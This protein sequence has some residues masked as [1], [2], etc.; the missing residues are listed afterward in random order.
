MMQED[1]EALATSG[2]L[3]DYLLATSIE[4]IPEETEEVSPEGTIRVVLCDKE[5]NTELEYRLQG[6]KKRSEDP[7]RT[8]AIRR[9][10]TFSPA[11]RMDADYVCK[12]STDNL[13]GLIIIRVKRHG[14][15]KSLSLSGYDSDFKFVI[16]K[17]IVAVTCMIVS[18]ATA[19]RWMVQYPTGDQSMLRRQWLGAVRQLWQ[20]AIYLNHIDLSPSC[21]MM[22]LG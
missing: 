1:S 5:T 4:D 15:S 6:M 22:S 14:L 17:C 13:F 16:L 9:S 18:S 2:S 20:Q 21:H 10:Q 19:F 8:G 12:V 11:G 3:D 7:L